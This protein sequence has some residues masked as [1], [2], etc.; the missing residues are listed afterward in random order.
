M[1]V[2][3]I[4]AIEDKTDAPQ[5]EQEHTVCQESSNDKCNVENCKKHLCSIGTFANVPVKTNDN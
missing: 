2:S 5:N 3:Q 1:H 4:V